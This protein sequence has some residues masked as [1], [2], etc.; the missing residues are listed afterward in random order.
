ME[1]LCQEI[2]KKFNRFGDLLYFDLLLGG[3]FCTPTLAWVTDSG[4]AS[5]AAC[6]ARCEWGGP[7][8]VYCTRA[9]GC[10]HVHFRELSSTALCLCQRTRRAFQYTTKSSASNDRFEGWT[11]EKLGE[12]RGRGWGEGRRERRWW[13]MIWLLRPEALMWSS[14]RGLKVSQ[15][16]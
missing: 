10:Q 11:D 5:L 12:R 1:W 4:L 3:R 8:R 9:V 7:S 13:K 14:Q 16:K 2:A 6:V 15:V